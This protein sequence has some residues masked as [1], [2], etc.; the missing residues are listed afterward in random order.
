MT[1]CAEVGGGG[2]GASISPAIL[3]A[4]DF[5]RRTWAGKEE[6]DSRSPASTS[7]EL[8]RHRPDRREQVADARE[9]PRRLLRTFVEA[10]RPRL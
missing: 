7:A 9:R 8:R 10:M 6:K 1:R 2:V 3:S 5:V 4:F